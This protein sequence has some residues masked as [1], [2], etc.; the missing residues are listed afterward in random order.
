VITVNHAVVSFLVDRTAA[1]M[2]SLVSLINVVC[3]ICTVKA[4][5]MST[6]PNAATRLTARRLGKASIW[7]SIIGIIIGVAIIITA[8]ILA[9]F[10]FRKVCEFSVNG[11][12]YLYK[13]QMSYGEC[14]LKG[15]VHHDD[16]YCY[17]N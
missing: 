2:L 9:V 12:C 7:I 1:C 4:Q 15:Y 8:V 5:N 17:Y 3:G 13:E 11:D 10:A 16:N 14:I 6:S